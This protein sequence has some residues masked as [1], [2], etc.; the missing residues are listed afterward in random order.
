M[1]HKLFL[2]F[3]F[4]VTFGITLSCASSPPPSPV[5][6]ESL[7]GTKWLPASPAPFR[8]ALE[9]IDDKECYYTVGSTRY[10]TVYRIR[11]Y[12]VEL[13]A[14]NTHYI[15]DGDYLYHKIGG[16]PVFAKV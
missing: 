9:I 14:L 6:P 13:P 3:L 5:E 10:H 11:G 12:V 8:L 1:K 16:K 7:I 15:I 2:S 4:V